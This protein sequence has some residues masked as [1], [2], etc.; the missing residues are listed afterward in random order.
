MKNEIIITIVYAD[1][2]AQR[3]HVQNDLLS[4]ALQRQ[5]KIPKNEVQTYLFGCVLHRTEKYKIVRSRDN[6]FNE[7][8]YKQE[9]KVMKH[10]AKDSSYQYQIKLKQV[11]HLAL[12]GL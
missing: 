6:D 8:G 1:Y 10:F 7:F 12:L 5:L 2:E 9:S 3:G 11:S 4:A